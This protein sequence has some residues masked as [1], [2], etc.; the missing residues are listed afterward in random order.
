MHKV[1]IYCFNA[2]ITKEQ[3]TNK[4]Y[5]LKFSATLINGAVLVNTQKVLSW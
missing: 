2:A 3:E 5:F 1:P 4:K